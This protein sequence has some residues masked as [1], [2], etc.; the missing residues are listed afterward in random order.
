LNRKKARHII[1]GPDEIL[2]VRDLDVSLNGKVILE[3]INFHVLTGQAVGV[4]GPNGAGKTTL[5]RAILGLISPRQGNIFL[6][7][8]PCPYPPDIRQKIGYLPQQ[9]LFERRFP[10]SAADVVATGLLSPACLL[11]PFSVR[12]KA[13]II[14]A[15]TE[16][17]LEKAASNPFSSLSGGEQQRI[18][19]ARALIRKPSLLLL[20]EPNAGLDF[21]AQLQF[22]KLLQRLQQEQCLTVVLVSHDLVAAA[23]FAQALICVNRIMHIHG[24]PREVLKSRQLAEAYR[25]QYDFLCSALKKEGPVI[26]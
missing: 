9:P 17:G 23:E 6:M 20:D 15:L 13:A 4:I 3:N 11:R 18:L 19:L 14:E 2:N 22:F 16:V 5:L 7:G 21:T 1:K 26:G 10:F 12:Q 24:H 25:C 8:Q